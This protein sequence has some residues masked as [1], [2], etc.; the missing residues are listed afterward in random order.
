MRNI[1]IVGGGQAGLLLAL[2]LQNHDYPVTLVNN[3]D[4]EE[5]RNGKVLSSQCLFHTALEIEHKLGI[6][7][8]DHTCPPIEGIGLKIIDP[9]NHENSLVAWRAR[10]DNPAKAVDQRMKFPALMD[11]FAS[12]GG[13]LV[14]QEA[15]IDLLEKLA[16]D[17][18]LVILAGGKGEITQQFATNESLSAFTQP[19]RVLSLAYVHGMRP[20]A[21]HS[22]ISFNL[23]PGAG[24]YFVIP[25][26]TFSGPCDIMF[27]EAIP[28]G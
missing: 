16:N 19:Q 12:R 2:G 9:Q 22:Q 8:W 21:G 10:L 17:H 4:G 13:K 3:R 7:Q 11:Q 25:A 18:D 28:L 24:E 15:D 6:E 26:L 27:F 5:I 14:I 1:A 23:L 20:T